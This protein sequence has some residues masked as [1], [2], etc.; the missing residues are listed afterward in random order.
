M[1][2]TL[3]QTTINVSLPEINNTVVQ[4]QN[5]FAINVKKQE[6]PVII[7]RL[8]LLVITS[9]HLPVPAD[10]SNSLNV[11]EMQTISIHWNSVKHSVSALNVPKD[12]LTEQE[13]PM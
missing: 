2:P 6:S 13:L 10:L 4:L 5:M 8:L 12:D 9:M 3:A 11:E 7:H 1:I